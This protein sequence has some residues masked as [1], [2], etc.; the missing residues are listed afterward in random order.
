GAHL[1]GARRR[2]GKLHRRARHRGK[3]AGQFKDDVLFGKLGHPIPRAPPDGVVPIELD[4]RP[5][6][7]ERAILAGRIPSRLRPAVKS[8]AG[9]GGSHHSRR[10]T[11]TPVIT[12]TTTHTPESEKA[13]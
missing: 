11:T 4:A 10:A 3:R 13:P 5:V 8:R 12:L 2:A 9:E 1:P 6:N 7:P